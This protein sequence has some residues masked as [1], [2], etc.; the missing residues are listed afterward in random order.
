MKYWDSLVFV[1]PLVNTSNM[2]IYFKGFLGYLQPGL[3]DAKGI[4]VRNTYI[5]VAY[6]GGT[7]VKDIYMKR[8]YNKN[9]CIKNSC[10]IGYLYTEG[11]CSIRITYA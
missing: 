7:C 6:I 4:D 9:I 2:L 1:S 5:G 11:A 8:V 10:S 3:F